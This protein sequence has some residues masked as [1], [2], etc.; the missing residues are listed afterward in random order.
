MML[1]PKSKTGF[2]ECF[3]SAACLQHRDQKAQADCA[4]VRLCSFVVGTC[5]QVETRVEPWPELTLPQN[6]QVETGGHACGA[7]STICQKACS[8]NTISVPLTAVQKL[9]KHAAG[10]DSLTTK[11]STKASL[12]QAFPFGPRPVLSLAALASAR[13]WTSRRH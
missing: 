9:Q 12:W 11:A 2:V 10:G 6:R 5:W 1:E 7:C 4:Q 13:E 3:R 8:D